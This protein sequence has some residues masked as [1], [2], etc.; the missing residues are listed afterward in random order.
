MTSSREDRDLEKAY[1]HGVNSYIVKPVDFAQFVEVV[2]T[3]GLYWAVVNEV[4]A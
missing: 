3:I 4:P 1:G 2:A